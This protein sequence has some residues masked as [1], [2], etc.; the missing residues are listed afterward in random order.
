MQ[1]VET[2]VLVVSGVGKRF[3]SV[4]ALD[5]VD[6]VVSGG[7]LV[8]LLGPNGAGKSTLL[9]LITG[10]FTPDDGRIEVFGHDLRHDAVAALKHIGAVFQQPTL[11]LELSIRANLKFHC[12]LYGIPGKVARERIDAALKRFGLEARAKDATRKLSGGNR[13]KVELARA[14]LHEPRLLIMDEATVGLDPA[15]RRDLMTHILEVKERERAGVLWTTHLVDEAARA[16][17]VV[18]L[19]KGRIMFSGPPAELAA[20][21]PRNDLGQA[22]LA[23]VGQDAV[24]APVT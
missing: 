1:V 8:A 14:L 22:F 17:R 10:L 20:Q 6:L 7:E 13:R 19:N 24:P 16:D 15:S 5:G 23:M 3:G 11:D 18:V 21:S 12:D 4:V 9:Q 2:P